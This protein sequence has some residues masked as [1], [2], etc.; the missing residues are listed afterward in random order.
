MPSL[1][2]IAPRLGK[3][4]EQVR[5]EH[6][7]RCRRCGG[8]GHVQAGT[9]YFGYVPGRCPTCKGTGEEAPADVH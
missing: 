5:E 4:Q 7:R 1:T 3:A 6:A 9:G 8:R 2:E